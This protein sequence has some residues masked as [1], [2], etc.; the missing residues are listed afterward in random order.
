MRIAAGFI[1]GVGVLA[2]A[3]ARANDKQDFLTCDGFVHPGKQGDGL[4]GMAL[5]SHFG[6]LNFANVTVNACTRAL[7]SPRLLPTQ[8]L[9]RVHLLRARAAAHLRAGETKEGVADLDLADAAAAPL[10]G[11]AFYR[12]S[13]GTSMTLLRAI[14]MA[15]SGDIHGA[16]TLVQTAITMRPY[17]LDVQM[18]AAK[19]LQADRNPGGVSP[20]PWVHAG[21]L[22]PNLAATALIEEAE[23]GNFAAVVAMR[24]GVEIDWPKPKMNLMPFSED[25]ATAS[26]LMTAMLVTVH[27]AYAR[28]ATGDADGARR[29]MAE[30]RTRLAAL[31][32]EGTAEKAIPTNVIAFAGLNHAQLDKFAELRGK[33]V[34]ARIAIIEKRP[35]DALSALIATPMPQ[36]AASAELLTALKA[37]LPADRAALVPDATPILAEAMGKRREQLTALVPDALI[38]AETP[39]SVVDY[40]RARPNILG[41]LVAGALSMGTSLLGGIS[42]TDGFRSTNN[43]DGTLKV[44]FIGNTPSPTLVQEMTLLRAAELTR[45]AGKPSFVIVKRADYTRRMV[46][47]QYGREIGSTP[48]GFKSELTIRFLD[49]GMEPARSI[50]AVGVIDAL[51]PLYYEEKKAA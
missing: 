44:E 31:R 25:Q 15:Q 20:S 50:N 39:R 6:G 19:I 21:R 40:S 9:R 41:A 17:A 24:N 18:V 11:D 1:L 3:P 28:A 38:A 13:M 48:T 35:A 32:P 45:E 7:A 10:A 12:R 23:I 22:S 26:A 51:G 5:G 47:T 30:L 49:A 4:R 2:A 34:D 36:N 27:T 43:S 16:S 29:D 37:A 33:Q 14:A 8:T 42:R 46:T